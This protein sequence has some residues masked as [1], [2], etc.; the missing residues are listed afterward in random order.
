MTKAAELLY[1]T[2]PTLSYAIKKIEEELGCLLFDRRGNKIVLNHNGRK[3][4]KYCN[5]CAALFREL[6]SDFLRADQ[7]DGMIRIK[8]Y[9]TIQAIIVEYSKLDAHTTFRLSNIQDFD[10]ISAILTDNDV[11][12]GDSSYVE[13]LH[14]E[15]LRSQ[16]LFEDE[17]LLSVLPDHPL[18]G[19]SSVTLEEI[20]AY[21]LAGVRSVYGSGSLQRWVDELALSRNLKF[22]YAHEVTQAYWKSLYSSPYP[23]FSRSLLCLYDD[24]V[25]NPRVY[26]PIDSPLTRKEINLYYCRRNREKLGK[27]LE[28]MGRVTELLCEKRK[29]LPCL[30]DHVDR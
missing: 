19:R 9:A 14:Q 26:I 5:R 30:P 8:S 2:Q 11:L 17:L 23:L 20:S 10:D 21:S 12:I 25:I 3:L 6:H 13:G 29:L 28:T 24:C 22:Q 18:A 27:F 15:E 4:L 16:F 1:V 7:D